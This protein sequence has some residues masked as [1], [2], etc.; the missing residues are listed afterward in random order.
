MLLLSFIFFEKIKYVLIVHKSKNIWKNF[1]FAMEY[2]FLLHFPLFLLTLISP[3]GALSGL[4]QFLATESSLK[5]IKNAFYFTLNFF[6]AS[7]Y[8]NFSLNFL[9]MLKI[10]LDQ[11]A[12]DNFKIYDIGTWETIV[13]YI[14]LNISRSKGNQ[15]TKFDQFQ[16]LRRQGDGG[17]TERASVSPQ[18]SLLMYPF[19][20]EVTKNVH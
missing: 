11:K 10:Q 15:A 19:L 7:R 2:H 17:E 1:D 9:V 6:P 16:V 12:E 5:I 13:M 20:K 3:Q 4:R 18:S 8:L 14:L